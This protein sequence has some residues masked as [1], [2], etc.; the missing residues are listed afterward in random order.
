[1]D[2]E[3]KEELFREID[4][5]DKE[6]NKELEIVLEELLPEAFA[7]VKETARRFSENETIESLGLETPTLAPYPA[8][9]ETTAAPATMESSYQGG[10]NSVVIMYDYDPLYRL[11]NANYS[12]GNAFA[13]IYDD[14][15][16]KRAQDPPQKEPDLI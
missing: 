6:W 14:S 15:T 16:A 5:L 11:V 2:P 1:M 10:D 12:D 8:P 3:E 9:L 7:V 13:Y 4:K